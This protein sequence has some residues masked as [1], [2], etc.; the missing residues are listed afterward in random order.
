[1]VQ[2]PITTANTVRKQPLGNE[3]LRYTAPQNLVGPAIEGF[4][5]AVSKA[6]TV[7]DEIETVHARIEANREA[8]AFSEETRR[9]GRT[10]KETLGEGADDAAESGA[11]ELDKVRQDIMGRASPRAQRMLESELA[12]RMVVAKDGFADHGFSQ[13]VKAFADTS[14]AAKTAAL[15]DAADE[16]DE[17]KALVLLQP[18]M[19]K[20]DEQEQFFGKGKDWGD[21]E[22]AKVKSDF[23]VSRAKK[24]AH[25]SATAAREYVMKH[26]D[27]IDDGSFDQM[28]N[29][30]ENEALSEWAEAYVEGTPGAMPVE[31]RDP[32]LPTDGEAP[33]APREETPLDLAKGYG[34]TS[35]IGQRSA[36]ATGG[37]RRGSSNHKGLDLPYP[38]GT[39]VQ[40]ALSGVVRTKNDPDG[41][42]RYA[43]IDHGGGLETRY[44]HLQGFF[45]KD[46]TR[47][48]KGDVIGASGST[49]NS[50]GPHLHY[51]ARQD[52]RPIDPSS[53]GK[54]MVSASG[55][56]QHAGPA[57]RPGMDLGTGL[58]RIRNDPT[59][60]TKQRKAALSALKGR[61]NEDQAIRGERESEA[62]RGV[63]MAMIE[64][65]DSFTSVT[66]L[67][68]NLVTNLSPSALSS[69]ISAANSN[70]EQKPVP[71]SVQASIAYTQQTNPTAF[72]DPKVQQRLLS[73]GL[74]PSDLGPLVRGAGAA[75]GNIDSAKP[76]PIPP[77]ELRRAAETV[78]EARGL[79][80]PFK[81]DSDAKPG[82]DA[83]QREVQED[84]R[85]QLALMGYLNTA[86]RTWAVNNPGKVA[87]QEVVDGWIG[88]AL[89]KSSVNPDRRLYNSSQKDIFDS[90][91]PSIKS[92][93]IQSLSS[94]LGRAPSEGEVAR[95][96]REG[97]FLGIIR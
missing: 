71:L 67:P 25:T 66:Q 47:V 24:L 82:S 94:K 28:L 43:V 20:I 7:M 68:P 65:G 74:K 21:I 23:R 83:R 58:E 16:D 79:P 33:A 75:Q 30:Y 60:S 72:L 38:A 57:F 19:A 88:H 13:K 37:G 8:V 95:A 15:E 1:M 84:A 81:L 10:V 35:G 96:Y 69:V 22:R 27:E 51:E 40:A 46:G 11:A 97:V 36:P 52:G 26:R 2:V 6:A 44:A 48:K 41:Y 14:E 92:G 62:A 89:R 93:L 5:Q 4:G 91:K 53:I 50:S 70:R 45:V 31:E 32:L 49:G 59:L 64:L 76:T 63:T 90:M 18:A 17:A 73:Q 12:Q 85:E 34:V 29:A 9:I 54:R 86:A 39:E 80:N 78:F 56:N 87:G 77:A 3:R 61:Y 55:T 42:G